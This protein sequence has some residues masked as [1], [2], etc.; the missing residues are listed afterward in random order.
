M[1]VHQISN[2]GSILFPTKAK[3]KKAEQQKDDVRKDRVNLSDEAKALY[4]SE[5]SNR[6]QEIRE[7]IRSG[8]YFQREVTEEIADGM[9]GD[10]VESGL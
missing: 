1:T 6:I 9:I 4:E 3:E 10:I 5:Q 8:Y 2:D 7:R